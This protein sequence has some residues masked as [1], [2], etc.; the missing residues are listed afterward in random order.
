MFEITQ[1]GNNGLIEFFESLGFD[2]VNIN[3]QKLFPSFVGVD[4]ESYS[5]YNGV[6]LKYHQSAGIIEL[7]G[8]DS[9]DFL[10]RIATNSMAD[11]KKEEI[12]RT[13]FTSEKGRIIGSVAVINLDGYLLL[14]GN[15]VHKQK[16][17]SWINKYTIIDDVK[18]TDANHRFNLFEILGPQ[19]NS[20][21]SLIC[22][23]VITDIEENYFKVVNVD[24]ILFFLVKLLDTRGFKKFWILADLENSK[25]ILKYIQEN[26]GPFDFNLIGEDA[27]KSYKIEQGIPSEPFE[28]N[29]NYNPHEAR[30]LNLV[31]FKKGCYIG[32]EVIARLDTYDKVQKYLMGVGF[33]E[34]FETNGEMNLFDENGNEVGV[35]T[36]TTFSPR[37]RKQIGLGYV[38]KSFALNGQK[39]FIKT[40]S[41]EQEVTVHELPFK[42]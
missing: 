32:Q 20:F 42:K 29:D 6:G 16:V 41:N 23:D 8:N 22:G 26:K 1:N 28:L 19:S 2:S 14:I 12:R 36:S 3:G 39:L 21:M 15:D 33:S 25:K 4:E 38:R 34:K 30:M 10:H 17:M 37:L 40:E 31:D 7:R 24:G 27:Y 9:L 5:L 35:V 18:T 11:L 13:I